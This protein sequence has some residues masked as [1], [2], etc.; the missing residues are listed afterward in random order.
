VK[1]RWVS[2][3]STINARADQKPMWREV[4]FPVHFHIGD[5]AEPFGEKRE[6]LDGPRYAEGYL[7]IV[8]AAY[9]QAKTIYEQEAF[10]PV[11]GALAEQGAV[12][13]RFTVRGALGSIQVRLHLE[14]KLTAAQ[15]AIRDG[16]ERGLALFDAGWRWD[17]EN[18][19]LRIRLEPGQTA[20]PSVLDISEESEETRRLYGLDN[21]RTAEYGR[22][23]LLARRL[24]EQGVRF[25]Q[26]FLNGQ[27]WDTHS[28]NAEKLKE[29]WGMTDQP[30]AALV[31]DLK[32]R[33]LLDSTIA[34]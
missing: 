6:R 24:V 13:V 7:P 11:R 20:G 19:E 5:R 18:K 25:V 27:P 26:I 28:K 15:G 33:G 1:A 14:G 34:L 8:R 32:R 31:Q 30:S 10:A 4:G 22:R 12:A 23:C 3:G 21:P 29:L 17:G 9:R 2:N 16:E